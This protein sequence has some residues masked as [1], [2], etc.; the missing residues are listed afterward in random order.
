MVKVNQ[1]NT[2]TCES[3]G[4]NEHGKCSKCKYM[5]DINSVYKCSDCT[6]INI[7]GKKCYWKKSRLVIWYLL[8]N[9]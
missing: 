6:H 3:S 8:E 9:C 1:D 5:N 2:T 4:K 7:S